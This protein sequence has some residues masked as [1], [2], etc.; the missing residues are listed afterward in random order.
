MSHDPFDPDPWHIQVLLES[1]AHDLVAL[2]QEYRHAR[3]PARMS[4]IVSH[5]Y[6]VLEVLAMQIPTQDAPIW[7][8]NA[9][10]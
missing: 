8:P 4:E 5:L 1:A 6:R 10:S 3:S 9:R 7:G 2:S